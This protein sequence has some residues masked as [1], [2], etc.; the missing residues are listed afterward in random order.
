MSNIRSEVG[1]LSVVEWFWNNRLQSVPSHRDH[2]QIFE[3]NTKR[4]TF[5]IIV[6]LQRIKSE[7]FFLFL[8][9]IARV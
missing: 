2:G 1:R 5:T 6:R 8:L 3:G 9:R 7:S 4:P